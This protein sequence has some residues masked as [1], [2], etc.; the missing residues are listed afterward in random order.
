MFVT[1]TAPSFGPVHTRRHGQVGQGLA[2]RP[3]RDMATCPHGVRMSCGE[4]H[5]DDDPCLGEPICPDCFDHEGAVLWNNALG[6]LWRRTT[7]I[8]LP[9]IL[10][11]LTGVTQKRLRDQ[12]RVSYV[13]VAE[14]QRRGLVHLHAVIRLDRA[15]PDYRNGELHP[16]SRRF[17]TE[18]L[19]NAIR[20]SAR[21]TFAPLPDE[22]GGGAVRW[23][24]HV[25]I[26]DLDS[27]ERRR[28]AGYL[29]KY[30]T[31][32]TEQAG[33]VLHRVTVE[34]VDELAVSEHMRRYL[35][36][37]FALDDEARATSDENSAA[38]LGPPR[39]AAETSDDP[40]RL[41][42]RTLQAMS[43]DEPVRVRLH[44]GTTHPGRIVRRT[45]NELVLD[46]GQALAFGDV[47]LIATAPDALV[48]E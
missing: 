6:E 13:K 44:D 43:H 1:F 30:A 37:G 7:P 45:L 21:E 18:L 26:R 19:E 41:A 22:L 23:G 2:C 42:W 5:P 36:A 25:D 16:P 29:A 10:A 20:T 4:V 11:R 38:P 39:P 32:S 35:R 48:R 14:Y 40:N 33:G 47:R 3:R 12:V 8:Y 27:A 24:E 15:M 31:K 28:V 17:T 9:R 34:Q 46:D